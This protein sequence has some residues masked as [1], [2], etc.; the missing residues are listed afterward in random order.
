MNAGS[1]QT[2]TALLI[3]ALKAINEVACYVTEEEPAAQREGL[4]LIGTIARTTI[5]KAE[6]KS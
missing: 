1:S 6:G 5:V 3:D 2:M 4:L